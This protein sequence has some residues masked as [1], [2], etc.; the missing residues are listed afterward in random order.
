MKRVPPNKAGKELEDNWA[1][2][3]Q[4]VL[5]NWGNEKYVSSHTI[6]LEDFLIYR[7]LPVV[8]ELRTIMINHSKKFRL[9]YAV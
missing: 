5:T 1:E 9:K 3:L 8:G 2:V 4:A 7:E 6:T